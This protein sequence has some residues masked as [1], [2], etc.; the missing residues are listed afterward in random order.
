MIPEYNHKDIDKTHKDKCLK[1]DRFKSTT[2]N[3]E[4]Y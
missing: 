2:D 3:R 4:K 1:E